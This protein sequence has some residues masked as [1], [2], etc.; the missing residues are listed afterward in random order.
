MRCT[1]KRI[2]ITSVTPRNAHDNPRR[3]RSAAPVHRRSPF[4][5]RRARVLSSLS[6]SL[7]LSSSLA[8]SVSLFLSPTLFL[9]RNCRHGTSYVHI[10][11]PR[12]AGPPPLPSFHA[13]REARPG[14]ARTHARTHGYRYAKRLAHTV[15][16]VTV[17]GS[18]PRAIGRTQQRAHRSRLGC[19]R[20]R[21]RFT[22]RV[23]LGNDASYLS[24]IYIGNST[25][26]ARHHRRDAVARDRPI[27]RPRWPDVAFVGHAAQSD[28]FAA[29]ATSD[30]KVRPASPPRRR[31]GANARHFAARARRSGIRRHRAPLRAGA[32]FEPKL[33]T[34]Y[35]ARDS[36]TL[37]DTLSS[38]FPSCTYIR[39]FENLYAVQRFDT[40]SRSS[41]SRYRDRSLSEVSVRSKYGIASRRARDVGV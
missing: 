25:N 4:A 6:V 22:R 24:I 21:G 17:V 32:K 15:A 39:H 12:G 35:S 3:S 27:L 2:A 5:R 26:F 14:Q 13:R 7:S 40:R 29:T 9:S 30:A 23:A 37:D 38:L 19:S 31:D 41:I 11:R 16:E 20:P 1:D 18:A 36:F 34:R 8:D 28:S 33:S 10:G